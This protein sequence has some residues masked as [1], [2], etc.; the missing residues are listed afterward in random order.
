VFAA[1][2][3]VTLPLPVADTGSTSI[4]S[5][6]SDTLQEHASA[7]AVTITMWL[8][9]AA[10]TAW[11]S[12]EMANEHDG[13]PPPPSETPIDVEVTL[14]MPVAENSSV[15]APSSPLIERSVKAASPPASVVAMVIPPSAPP[16]LAIDAAIVTPS[17][18]TGAPS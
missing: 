13:P 1:T 12:L 7:L 17:R 4:Q 5:A 3:I 2:V 8:P 11:E 9:P 18:A 10:V 6:L 15:R 14:A 16:P